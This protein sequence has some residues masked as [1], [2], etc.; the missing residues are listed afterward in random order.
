MESVMSGR[1][2]RI[3]ALVVMSLIGIGFGGWLVR[4]GFVYLGCLF[5]SVFIWR[6]QEFLVWFITPFKAPDDYYAPPLTSR[7][8]RVLLSVICLVAGIVCAVGVYLW[9]LWPEQWEAGFVF[10]LFGLLVLI[11]V[12][13]TEI[14]TRRRSVETRPTAQ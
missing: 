11:P 3:L 4:R 5:V 13:V 10:V 6:A 8:Q 12:T 7:W 1:Q 9:R 2:K 14:R